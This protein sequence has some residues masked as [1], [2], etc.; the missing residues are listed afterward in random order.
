MEQVSRV[1]F[2]PHPQS[3]SR[4]NASFERVLG[5]SGKRPQTDFDWLF[6]SGDTLLNVRSGSTKQH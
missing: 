4:I 1:W 5:G 2:T 6:S 3:R